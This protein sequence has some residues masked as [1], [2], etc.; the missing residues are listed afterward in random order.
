LF[1]NSFVNRERGARALEERLSTA[2]KGGVEGVAP[3]SSSKGNLESLASDE[4][5]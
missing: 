1:V 4:L 3:K 5:V 2:S